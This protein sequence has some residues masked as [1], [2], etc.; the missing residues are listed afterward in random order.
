M[1]Q[2]KVQIETLYRFSRSLS[3]A[4]DE[5]DVLQ[6]AIQI[7]QGAEAD[8][9]T[10]L[11]V[12]LDQEG[13]PE[14]CEAV[15]S[16]HRQEQVPSIPAGT[17]YYLP[18]FP[19][20]DL[21]LSSQDKARLV[22]DVT[23]DEQ[24]D[25]NTRQVLLMSGVHALLV[26]PL[27]Q[28]AQWVGLLTFS[29]GEPRELEPQALETYNSLGGLVSPAV[30]SL[31][32]VRNL[33]RMVEER[34]AESTRLQQKMIEA[35]QQALKEL[36]TP[37]IPILDQILV[38]PL[39]GEIDSARARDIMRALL[40]AVR[41]R[42]ASVVIL[43]ITG[44]PIVDSGVAA[45]LNKTIRAAQ[46]KGAQTIITGISE[47]VAEAIVDLGIDWGKIDTLSDLQTGLMAALEKV[48]RRIV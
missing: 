19:I 14:W 31:R 13:N 5:N 47:E 36:S 44:V 15:G 37:I 41:E 35:Q 29:W 42:R 33:E 27:T 17:R 7:A 45:H 34:T 38:M 21:W 23:T 4:R 18:E 40:A 12:D 6:V 9:V 22:A 3:A 24:V 25:E 28:A 46:L 48:G 20:T 8:A 26:I 10:L 32:L 2:S 16:W 30:A 39:V 1:E 11:Y 43:D